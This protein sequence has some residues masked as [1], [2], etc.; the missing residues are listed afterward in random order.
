MGIQDGLDLIEQL[1]GNERRVGSGAVDASSNG[2]HLIGCLSGAGRLLLRCLEL[3]DPPTV[4][5]EAPR[6]IGPRHGTRARPSR[7]VAAPLSPCRQRPTPHPAWVTC[8]LQALPDGLHP[9]DQAAKLLEVDRGEALK[10][11][12]A[13]GC[14]S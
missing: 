14:E 8:V 2:R 12:C 11:T 6:W 3:D 7:G 4:V 9:G 5:V 10:T 13:E 1:A